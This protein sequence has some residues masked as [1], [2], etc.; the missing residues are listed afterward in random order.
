MKIAYLILFILFGLKANAQDVPVKWATQETFFED[1]IGKP[2]PV[3]QGLELDEKKFSSKQ[4][5]NEIVVINFWFENCPPCIAE[6]PELNK[7]V[8]KY[9]KK[10]VRF[11]GIT[12]DLPQKARRF[13]KRVPYR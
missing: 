1:L 12:H 7:L 10:G 6:M 11:I 3:F 9:G 2:V 5:K 13:Q 4:L 8:A